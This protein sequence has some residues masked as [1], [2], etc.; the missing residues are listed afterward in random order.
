MSDS[1]PHFY[2]T[3]CSNV[4]VRRRDQ[5]RLR[6]EGPSE[7]LLQQIAAE[8]PMC[9]CGGRF[10]PGSN[11]KCPVCGGAFADQREP[12]I[13]LSELSMIVVC[14]ACVFGDDSDGRDAY[15]VLIG[16]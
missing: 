6:R 8:L 13:R 2:C 3:R 12:L 5:E 10:A 15:R 16:D 14:G 1:S 9:P 11:P 7:E 4:I